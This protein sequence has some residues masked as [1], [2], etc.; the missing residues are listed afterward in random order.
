M[1]TIRE[2]E[3]HVLGKTV[4][5]DAVGQDIYLPAPATPLFDP[6]LKHTVKTVEFEKGL[7]FAGHNGRRADVVLTSTEGVRIIVEVKYSNGKGIGYGFDMA[8]AGNWLALELDVARWK[9][10][11]T[12]LPDFSRPG[13]L[14]GVLNQVTWLNPGKPCAVEWLPYTEVWHKYEHDVP[15]DR[16]AESR[17]VCARYGIP[18]STVTV[19][20]GLYLEHGWE[21]HRD[22]RRGLREYRIRQPGECTPGGVFEGLHHGPHPD[23]VGFQAF[24][25]DHALA[26]V[27]HYKESKRVPGRHLGEREQED[28]W[29]GP[30][31]TSW[32]DAVKDLF[33]YRA[34]GAEPIF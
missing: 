6:P 23:G 11:E 4:F 17:A 8:R 14:Q 10:D 21:L 18:F 33:G 15:G 5:D 26:V 9:D 34:P 2:S 20:R 32:K 7:P 19:H 12:L 28:T 16:D 31:R 24:D 25:A 22:G 27:W 3:L 30:V 29:A 1:T 13:T